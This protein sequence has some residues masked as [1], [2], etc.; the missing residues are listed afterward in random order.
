MSTE[1]EIVHAYAVDKVPVDQLALEEGVSR[2]TI[3][4][5]LRRHGHTRDTKPKPVSA[6]KPARK[7]KPAD[8]RETAD[9]VARFKPWAHHDGPI[10]A[11]RQDHKAIINSETLFPSTVVAPMDS[12]RLLVSGHNNPKVGRKVFKGAW[13]GMPIFT[14]TLEERKTCPSSCAMWRSCYGN[15]MQMARRN[16][17]HHPDF[18]AALAAEVMTVSRRHPEGIVVRLH[19][20]G[21]FYSAAYVRVWGHLLAMLPG[22][23]AFGY[24]ARRTDVDDAESQLIAAEIEKLN[25]EY[26]DRWVIRTS[27]P[28]FGPMRSVVVKAPVNRP[29]AIMCPA[30]TESTAACATCGLC[31]SEATRKK[32]IVFREHGHKAGKNQEA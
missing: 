30:Q 24:T 7:K 2:E 17:A 8:M 16:D 15:G 1:S 26:P 5:I 27:H 4:L 28:D 9:G 31:W 11:L 12:P 6:P 19:V 3:Y 25:T 18:I 21:D 32:T 10:F 14:L 20:L 22:L 23:H 29:D 13:A